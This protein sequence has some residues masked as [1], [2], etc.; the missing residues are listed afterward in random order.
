MDDGV[1]M[2]AGDGGCQSWKWTDWPFDTMRKYS[3]RFGWREMCFVIPQTPTPQHS[4]TIT[5]IPSVPIVIFNSIASDA[6]FSNDDTARETLVFIGAAGEAHDEARK[7]LEDARERCGRL[8]SP[9]E[10]ET[11]FTTS[12][13]RH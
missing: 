10:L 11:N 7:V 5:I 12:S 1:M 2:T 13:L 3:S 9:K 8:C 6:L 4:T